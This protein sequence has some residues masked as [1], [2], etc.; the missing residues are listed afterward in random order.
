MKTVIPILKALCLLVGIF[1]LVEA[2]LAF[3]DV[4]RISR[5]ASVTVTEASGAAV[6]LR[7]TAAAVAEYA[8][9]QTRQLMDP[10]NQKA[11]DAGI[12]ALAVFNG[13]GRLI[14]REVIP[15]AMEVLDNLSNATA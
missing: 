2:G 11:L 7:K 13:T 10:R 14:N 8:Q 15:R 5:A 9:H 1:A 6:E 12:Q 4:A 3:R